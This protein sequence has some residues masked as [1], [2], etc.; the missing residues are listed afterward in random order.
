MYKLQKEGS[1]E[2][3]LLIATMKRPV[4][5]EMEMA[6]PADPPCL[7]ELLLTPPKLAGVSS[8]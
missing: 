5:I 6:S 3:D 1:I 2:Q 8:N 7:F 4:F